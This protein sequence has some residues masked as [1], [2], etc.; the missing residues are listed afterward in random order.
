M[1]E[2][3]DSVI[4]AFDSVWVSVTGE[5]KVVRLSADAQPEV[6]DEFE[7][8]DSPEGL[9]ASSRAIWVANSGDGSLSQIVEE[10]GDVR[11]V[12]NVGGQPVDVAIGAG[13]VWVADASDSS[14]ARV[15][16]GRGVL[17]ATVT[18]IGPNPRAV[19][20]IGRDVWVATSGDGRAWRIDGDTNAAT[21]SVRVGGTPRDIATDGERLFVT[22]REG[23][24]V[25][26]ID[27]Q[28]E[29][30]RQ[31]AN[32]VEDGPLS[33]AVDDRDLWVTR[34]D[35]GDVARIARR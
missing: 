18:G 20:I 10:T 22:D 25:V 32:T 13:A 12:P 21:G 6:T 1:G 33:V 27:P 24:R 17:A 8:G 30:G 16:G 7:V 5:N 15:D 3:P 2:N 9:A 35:G 14:V 28:A 26:E 34:F 23:D 4:V 29:A 11:S 31:A 19:T